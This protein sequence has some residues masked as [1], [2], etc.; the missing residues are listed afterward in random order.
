MDLV[1]DLSKVL[2]K[3]KISSNEKTIPN[4]SKFVV[5]SSEVFIKNIE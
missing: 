5:K 2:P 3:N 1:E 4:A